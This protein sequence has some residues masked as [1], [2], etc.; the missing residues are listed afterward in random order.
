MHSKKLSNEF[1]SNE[2]IQYE[3]RPLTGCGQAHLTFNEILERELANDKFNNQ[4]NS[5]QNKKHKF[6]KKN[7]SKTPQLNLEKN[8]N[9]E[10]KEE[11]E[12]IEKMPYIQSNP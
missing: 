7:S 10:Q 8:K 1:Y 11:E 6:L 9:K 4:T 5:S 12:K 3:D 2:K